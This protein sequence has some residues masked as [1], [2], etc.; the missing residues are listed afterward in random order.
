MFSV[1]KR[2]LRKIVGLRGKKKRKD[3]ENFILR[4]F[5]ISISYQILLR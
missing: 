4:I 1:D 5:M 3:G 2:V